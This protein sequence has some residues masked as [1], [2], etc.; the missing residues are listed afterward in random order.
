MNNLRFFL[1]Y[2]S[3]F[4]SLLLIKSFLSEKITENNW[5][6]QLFA[7]C[8]CTRK[9]TAVDLVCMKEIFMIIFNYYRRCKYR[10]KIKKKCRDSF[11]M[12][13]MKR[14]FRKNESR[15]SIK[16]W[17]ASSLEYVSTTATIEGWGNSREQ[18]SLKLKQKL[19]LPHINLVHAIEFSNWLNS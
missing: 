14:T 1:A 12:L 19:K 6:I 8:F 10:Y 15:L 16:K 9:D 13:L 3:N 11:S 4:Q 17:W 2:S 5:K 7:R 18:P